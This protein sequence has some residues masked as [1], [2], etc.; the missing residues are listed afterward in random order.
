MKSTIIRIVGR[1]LPALGALALYSGCA[2]VVRG[3]TEMLRIETEPSGATVTLP[4]G[5]ASC[6]APCVLE[7]R[8]RGPLTVAAELDGC[9]REE[10]AVESRIDRFGGWTL[11]AYGGAV[12]GA[13]AHDIGEDV[14]TVLV[15]GTLGADP[16]NCLPAREEGDDDDMYVLLPIVPAAV[17]LGTGVLFARTPNPLRIVLDCR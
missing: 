1:T 14:A 11:G 17:D 3:P 15:C 8:R 9:V 12:L 5:E 6:V 2:T 16:A 10:V 13:L 7:V 4:A